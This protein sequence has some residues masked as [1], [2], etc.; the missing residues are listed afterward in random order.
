LGR[1]EEVGMD[2][3]AGKSRI[4]IVDHCRHCS[5]T[6]S[7]L[8]R[9]LGCEASTAHNGAEAL[10]ASAEF[11]PDLVIIEI[12]LLGQ[13][14]YEVARYIRDRPWSTGIRMIAVTGAGR[15]VDEGRFRRVGF[16][17]HLTKPIDVEA[18]LSI[19]GRPRP[20]SGQPPD[21]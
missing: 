6:L 7:H 16:D 21:S 8:G 14:G 18:L 2:D 17:H 13:D 11:R 4:L 12:G 20:Q 15:T 9:L 3:L 5:T 1:S 10:E 19:I